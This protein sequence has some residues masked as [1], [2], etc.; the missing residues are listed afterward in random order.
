MPP[1]KEPTGPRRRGRPSEGAREAIVAAARELFVERD[2]DDVSTE[3]IIGRAGVSRGAMYHHFEGKREV[4][5]AAMEAVESEWVKRLAAAAANGETG[6]ERVRAGAHAYLD[7]AERNEEL[8][9]ILLLQGPFAIG[10]EAWRELA[11]RYGMRLLEIGIRDGMEDGSLAPADPALVAH[12]VLA[13]LS[14]CAILI[15]RAE[16]RAAT[17]ARAVAVFDAL[18]G[19]LRPGG[20]GQPQS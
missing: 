12:A 14:E 1:V 6:L 3:A 18:L 9:R 13:A 7:E 17:R 11:S 19:G 16:D 15:A 10:W 5:L 4:M 8:R 20:A 2:Y